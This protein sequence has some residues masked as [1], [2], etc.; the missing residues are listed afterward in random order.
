[1][2]VLHVC[3]SP[4]PL[5]D[6]VSRQLAVAFFTRLMEQNPDVNITNVDLYQN[7]PPYLTLDGLRGIWGSVMNPDFEPTDKDMKASAYS[8]E[9]GQLVTEADVLVLTMPLWNASA[10]AIMKAWIDQVIAPNVLFEFTPEGAR[11][12][13]NLRRVIL[14]VS[15]GAA[16]KED[17]PGDA[18]TP[19]IR[20]AFGFIDIEEFAVAWADGQNAQF[21]SDC[22]LRKELALEAVQELADEVA[23]M[24]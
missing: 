22:E 13:H 8:R 1:M 23:T 5:S 18:L 11:P 21:F 16:F 20:S 3:A 10:P 6:S 9:Q 2:N 19:M 17:D 4:K 15:S 14:L 12:L 7:P 24:A